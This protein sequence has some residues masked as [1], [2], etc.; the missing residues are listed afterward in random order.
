MQTLKHNH[1]TINADGAAEGAGA[2]FCEQVIAIAIPFEFAE[3]EALGIRVAELNSVSRAHAFKISI[4]I[5]P[6]AR[7]WM[8]WST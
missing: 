8:N 5:G 2:H 4:W 1:V 6:S 7:P 3:K